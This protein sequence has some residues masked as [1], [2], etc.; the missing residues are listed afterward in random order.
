M[1]EPPLTISFSKRSVSLFGV[2]AQNLWVS[3]SLVVWAHT[4]YKQ[5][6]CNF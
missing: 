5:L 6:I 2:L 3:E 1:V 4:T